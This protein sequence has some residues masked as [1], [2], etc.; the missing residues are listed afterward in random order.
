M[1]REVRLHGRMGGAM[2]SQRGQWRR[3]REQLASEGRLPKIQKPNIRRAK[4]RRDSRAAMRRLVK[5]AE[6][7]GLTP[8]AFHLR[9]RLR[10]QRS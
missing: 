2:L 10:E 6:G 8:A 5:E 9:R 1:V 7:S 3:I 4:L